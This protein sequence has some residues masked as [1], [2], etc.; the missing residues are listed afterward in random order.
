MHWY[1]SCFSTECMQSYSYLPACPFPCFGCTMAREETRKPSESCFMP[2]IP[3]I[4]QPAEFCG[5]FC[6]V[7]DCQL[8][9]KREE[10]QASSLYFLISLR[11]PHR[12]RPP[13]QYWNSG[14]FLQFPLGTFFSLLLSE[15]RFI[16]T[17]KTTRITPAVKR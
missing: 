11:R 2:T 10:A 1:I 17:A 14:Q 3:S 12:G 9:Q 15:N 5:S 6:G 4:M 8:L 7:F 13:P 16:S